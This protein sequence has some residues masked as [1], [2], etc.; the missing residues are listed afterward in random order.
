MLCDPLPQKKYTNYVIYPAAKVKIISKKSWVELQS[1]F[2][3]DEL[4]RFNVW[5]MG[6][7]KEI[8]T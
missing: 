4:K 1:I 3:G 2:G 6:K 8:M 7:P 5:V